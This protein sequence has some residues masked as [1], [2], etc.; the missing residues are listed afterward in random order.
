MPTEEHLNAV[1]ES[2]YSRIQNLM[3]P[4]EDFVYLLQRE[5]AE[6]VLSAED[7][8]QP[9]FGFF[10]VSDAEGI[11][12]QVF[13]E[14]VSLDFVDGMELPFPVE[15]L[16]DAVIMTWGDAFAAMERLPVR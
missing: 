6:Q 11:L 4:M 1:Y 8:E 16:E 7:F 10:T 2:I 14:P 13:G 3:I 9:F 15:G 5:L 12:T